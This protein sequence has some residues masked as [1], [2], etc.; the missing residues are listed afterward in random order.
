MHFSMEKS[1]PI[2]NTR[3]G[4]T[5][6][7]TKELSIGHQN[8]EPKNTAGTTEWENR[9]P[10]RK[11]KHNPSILRRGRFRII[12]GNIPKPTS[13]SI[14][15]SWLHSLIAF[16]HWDGKS[17]YVFAK[18]PLCF[19]PTKC[20]KWL[21]G[22]GRDYFRIILLNLLPL[23]SAQTNPFPH[24]KA[25]GECKSDSFLANDDVCASMLIVVELINLQGIWHYSFYRAK[26]SDEE[27][28]QHGW[29]HIRQSIHNP[30]IAVNMQSTVRGGCKSM[31]RVLTDRYVCPHS[32]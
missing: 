5:L 17:L 10:V 14:D 27:H 20:Y 30:N 15:R 28:G 16:R 3:K 24:P 22:A 25:I 6:A 12:I 19:F 4:H 23:N 29:V 18:I 7:C 8:K 26:V 31:T 9:K 21:Q 13:F 11:I 1:K 32:E 2:H